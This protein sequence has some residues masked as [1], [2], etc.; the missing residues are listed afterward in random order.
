MSKDELIESIIEAVLE[1]VSCKH[2]ATSDGVGKIYYS[3][4]YDVDSKAKVQ[5]EEL[6]K[7]Q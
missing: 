6:L 7:S 2:D 5:I 3:V 1:N 4:E